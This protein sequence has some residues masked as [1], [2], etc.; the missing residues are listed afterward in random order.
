MSYLKPRNLLLVLALVLALALVVLIALRY[1]PESQLEAVVKSL[2][3]GVDVSLEDIDYTHMEGGQRRWRLVSRQVSRTAASGALSL[4]E[5]ELKF[6]DAL[7]EPASSI[8]AKRGEV[9]SDYQSVKVLGDVVLQHVDGYALQTESLD[10]DHAKQRIST[11]AEVLMIAEGL[12]LEGKGL[13]LYLQEKRLQLNANV[14]AFI[15]PEK[16]K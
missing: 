14:D 4:D 8:R 10:Y 9:S 12:R 5:P 15:D 7:G 6:F 13:T 1:S 11:D 16:I 2:P 3:K